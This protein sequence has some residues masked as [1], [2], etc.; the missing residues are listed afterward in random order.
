[1]TFEQVNT[2]AEDIDS[3]LR[4][5]FEESISLTMPNNWLSDHFC[6]SDT[7]SEDYCFPQNFGIGDKETSRR[8]A[9]VTES[10]LHVG[11]DVF[12]PPITNR[13]VTT[14]GSQSTKVKYQ[15]GRNYA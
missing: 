1:M 15:A 4:D 8:R 10:R 12:S 14:G 13:G 5:S 6:E 11:G 9:A 3:S 7:E 2:K